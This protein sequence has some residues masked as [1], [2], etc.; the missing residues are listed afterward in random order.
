MVNHF[1]LTVVGRG[2]DVKEPSLKHKPV[3]IA[4]LIYSQH[5]DSQEEF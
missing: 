5:I 2:S 3:I 4:N 1:F